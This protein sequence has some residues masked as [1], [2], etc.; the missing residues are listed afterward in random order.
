MIDE[1]RTPNQWALDHIERQDF[2]ILDTETT[3]FPPDNH[4]VEIGI[5]SASGETLFNELFHPPVPITE[6]AEKV[7]GIS[8]EDVED[9]HSYDLYHADIVCAC[10]GKKV[11]AY[12][13]AFDKSV[14]EL[15]ARTIDLQPAIPPK[16]WHCAMLKYAAYHGESGRKGWR[17]QK[18]EN[19]VKQMGIT[20]GPQTHRAVDDCRLTLA[21]ME[22]MAQGQV[23]VR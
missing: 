6:G 13:A 10:Y 16:V 12:N 17:W 3:D 20:V 21:V 5:I 23:A 7:H 14:M 1:K 2:V 22:A 4:P 18:L 9:C 19:A 15:A 8:N 11:I